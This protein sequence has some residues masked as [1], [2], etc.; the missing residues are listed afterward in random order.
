MPRV[1]PLI[2]EENS[3]DISTGT[4]MFILFITAIPIVGVIA[5]GMLFGVGGGLMKRLHSWTH[6]V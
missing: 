1:A 5:L 6:K 3:D 2:N 4:W